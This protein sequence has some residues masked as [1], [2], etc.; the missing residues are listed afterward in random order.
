MSPKEAA[1][2]AIRLGQPLEVARSRTPTEDDVYTPPPSRDEEPQPTSL[3]VGVP[4]LCD[5]REASNYLEPGPCKY[6]EPESFE[7][8]PLP[9]TF[10]PF[11][12]TES[13]PEPTVAASAVAS[14]E[15]V[16][17]GG[18]DP[19]SPDPG[20]VEAGDPV[21]CTDEEQAEFA[22]LIEDLN[23]MGDELP[24]DQQRRLTELQGKC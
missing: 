24:L 8:V 13:E 11:T 18:F 7:F 16:D 6:F 20:S 12:P 2:T 9:K 4:S 3:G 14:F 23:V 10:T 1:I 19:D 15:A 21:L 5:D 22:A 17:I